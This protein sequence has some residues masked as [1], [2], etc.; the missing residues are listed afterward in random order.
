V[1]NQF[2]INQ[3]MK[4]YQLEEGYKSIP[5]KEEKETTNK[6]KLTEDA[7]S[8]PNLRWATASAPS[9]IISYIFPTCM[10]ILN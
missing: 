6:G 8:F 4:T 9:P 2:S 3:R 5:N 1:E 7:I 10:Y